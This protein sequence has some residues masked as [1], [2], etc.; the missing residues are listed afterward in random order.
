MMPAEA[1]LREEQ[2]LHL[3]KLLYEEKRK[4]LV[5]TSTGLEYF[6][7]VCGKGPLPSPGSLLLVRYTSRL[8]G[9]NGWKLD[10]SEN[11][12]DGGFVEPFIFKWDEENKKRFVPGFWEAVASMRA[13]GKRR[14]IV[15]VR[16]AY[17][18]ADDEP[19]PKSW[20]ARRRLLSV[21]NTNRDKTIVFDI[22]LL[23]IICDRNESG[24]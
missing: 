19:R 1:L 20:D 15:P 18:S 5:K 17:R 8:Q 16:I 10:S 12:E 13:G 22:E 21:L 23:K 24:I 9:L 7:I 4:E 6:D 2:E 11:H 14:A 3:P